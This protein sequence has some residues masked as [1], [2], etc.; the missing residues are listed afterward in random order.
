MLLRVGAALLVLTGAAALALYTVRPGG[1]ALTC[2]LADREPPQVQIRAPAGPVRGR[3]AVAVSLSDNCR[4]GE[5]KVY[6][7]GQPVAAEL[8]EFTFDTAALPDGDHRVTVEAADVSFRRNTARA[9]AVLK[10]D[11]T[12]PTLTVAG[13]PVALKQGEARPV[14][15]ASNEPLS[16][17][18][19]GWGEV[20]V[21]VTAGLTRLVFPI[22]A[23][24]ADP[25]GTRRLEVRAWDPAGNEARL[26][27]E[28]RVQP[29]TFPVDYVPV[30]P[31]LTPLLDP[32]LLAREEAYLAG[33]F[34]QVSWPPRWT[35]GFRLPL[36]GPVSS[37]FGS[38][39]Q[40]AGGTLSAPHLGVD[41]AVPAGTPVRAA[42]DG[43]VALAEPLKVRGNAVVIDHGL[44]VYTAYYHLSEIRV[45]PGQEVQAG[46]LLG[47][48][49]STGLSTG[50]HLHWELRVF[51]VP[52]DPFGWVGPGH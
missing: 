4:V 31:D 43:R 11:N 29:G 36:S 18:E 28:V 51:G 50:P 19:L 35:G 17:L 47:L 21:P 16:R 14:E 27:V 49:G 25:P 34:R 10:T 44:G 20:T 46:E 3:V 9:E 24:P 52:A 40:Y 38:R 39:R 26:G 8:P 41:L 48:V 22:A 15:I 2:Y 33:V 30:P 32:Q 5:V 45:R 1:V 12:P 37:A 13:G 23:G 42:A 7:D 6:L